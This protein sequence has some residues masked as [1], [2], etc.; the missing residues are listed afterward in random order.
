VTDAED[1]V[2]EAR[3]RIKRH[4]ASLLVQKEQL[5]AKVELA[6]KEL[7]AI[8][9]EAKQAA[10]GG[11]D[12]LASKYGEVITE[13]E[14]R[15]QSLREQ[16]A[17]AEQGYREAVKELS[18]LERLGREAERAA[19]MAPVRSSVPAANPFTQSAVD[20]AIA[21]VR[22]HIENLE[23]EASLGDDLAQ[24]RKESEERDRELGELKA[25]DQLA[26]LKAARGKKPSSD[27][28]EGGGDPP[29]SG[30]TL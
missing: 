9:G 3:V 28:S 15:L 26:A 4:A 6:E 1:A 13:L 5:D 20:F 18:E 29:P 25:K 2:N 16:R 8:H 17:L 23:A 22:E 24:E 11:R 27:G 12:D 7:A 30:R 21:N 10:A 14:E 19:V